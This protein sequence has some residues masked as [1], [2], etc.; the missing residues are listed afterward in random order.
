LV[1]ALRKG[2]SDAGFQE[3][4][5]VVIE[6]RWADNVLERLPALASELVQRRAAVIVGNQTA[7][8]A[9]KT[10]APST[11]II[12]VTGEVV[13]AGPEEALQA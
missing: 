6:Q 1:A 8:E 2:L 5:N 9:A 11:P 4:R 10:A 12:F 13:S 7:V 3:G